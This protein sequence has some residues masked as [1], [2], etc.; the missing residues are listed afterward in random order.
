MGL[1]QAIAATVEELGS[2]CKE[3]KAAFDRFIELASQDDF[4]WIVFDTIADGS[5]AAAVGVAD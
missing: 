2:S 5:H 4:D 3:E 1:A